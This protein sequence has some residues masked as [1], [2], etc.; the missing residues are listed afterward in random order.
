V[1]WIGR[2]NAS[3]RNKDERPLIDQF[4]NNG[5]GVRI[6]VP[7]IVGHA[8][9]EADVFFQIRRHRRRLLPQVSFNLVL[10]PLFF[11]FS[12]DPGFGEIRRFA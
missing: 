9:G 1:Q 5:E 8:D 12:P 4:H 2:E 11:S 6:F 3:E 10:R 7:I